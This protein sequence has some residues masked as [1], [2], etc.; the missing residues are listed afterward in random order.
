MSNS[1]QHLNYTPE[2]SQIDCYYE[3]YKSPSLRWTFL[4]M[5]S[6]IMLFTLIGNILVCLSLIVDRNLRTTANIFLVNMSLGDIFVTVTILLMHIAYLI[7]W[8]Y[9]LLGAFGKWLYNVGFLA[10]LTIPFLTL[11]TLSVDRYLSILYPF[12]YIELVTKK[13]AVCCILATWTYVGIVIVLI[14]VFVFSKSADDTNRRFMLPMNGYYLV[15]LLTHNLVPL[16]VVII[17][18]V[19]IYLVA[20]RHRVQIDALK[21]RFGERGLNVHFMKSELK[22]TRTVFIIVT[23][24]AL[25]WLPF[26]VMETKDLVFPHSVDCQSLERSAITNYMTYFNGVFNPVVYS[27][28]HRRFFI[29]FKKILCCKKDVFSSRNTELQRPEF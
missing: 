8:P 13:R 21:N 22:A 9:W 2:K 20:R 17:I 1:T 6:N 26:I 28:R 24:L 18:Y 4:V 3:F 25:S 14:S 27:L 12:R 23:V 11:M 16:I 29:V 5:L 7:H 10:L 15:L 19:R